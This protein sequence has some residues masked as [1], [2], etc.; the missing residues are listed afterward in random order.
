MLTVDL[1]SSTRSPQ[2]SVTTPFAFVLAEVTG[3]QT[4]HSQVPKPGIGSL[5]RDPVDDTE[6]LGEGG[7]VVHCYHGSFLRDQKVIVR[8]RPVM[9]GAE[10][11]QMRR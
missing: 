8:K 7:R 4:T 1:L 11:Q 6:E 9:L 3:L 10:R 5:M 2:F